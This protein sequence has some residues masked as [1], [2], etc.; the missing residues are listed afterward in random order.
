MLENKD[1]LVCRFPTCK[2]KWGLLFANCPSPQTTMITSLVNFSAAPSIN[3]MK[4]L[5]HFFAPRD[6]N[7]QCRVSVTPFGKFRKNR[8][9]H[10][11]KQN[12]T[13]HVVHFANPRRTRWTQRYGL[14]NSLVSVQ[15]SRSTPSYPDTW[16]N[17]EQWFDI[18]H[19]RKSSHFPTPWVAGFFWMIVEGWSLSSKPS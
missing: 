6:I 7:K 19:P 18:R 14:V 9:L 17:T 1:K 4:R 2:N 11:P 12:I 8:P 10:H 5:A 13:K 15:L 16:V 3:L